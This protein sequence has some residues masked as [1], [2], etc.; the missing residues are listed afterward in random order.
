[1]DILQIQVFFTDAALFCA[2]KLVLKLKN[3]YSQLPSMTLSIKKGECGDRPASSLVV[4]LGKALNR[5]AS[6][7]EW[8]DW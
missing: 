5:F 6:T 3:W 1:V 2:K 4:S 7:F 8:L